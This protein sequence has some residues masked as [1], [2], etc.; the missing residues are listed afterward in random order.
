MVATIDKR[1]RPMLTDNERKQIVSR[2]MV[3]CKWE[4][5]SPILKTG[6]I[7]EVAKIFDRDASTVSRIWKRAETNFHNG[8]ALTASPKKKPGRPKLYNA[9]EIGESIQSIP[10]NKRRTLRLLGNELGMSAATLCRMKNIDN[11]IVPHTNTILPL[12]TQE[13]EMT[14]FYFTLSKLDRNR[15]QFKDNYQEIHIDEK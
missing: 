2:L 7:A 5:G 4:D 8:G 12:L 9:D 10:S 13:H 14:R 11:V 15:K 1:K 3:G 6:R